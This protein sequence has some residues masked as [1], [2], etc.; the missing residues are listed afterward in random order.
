MVMVAAIA[1]GQ[2]GITL[3]EIADRLE[4]MRE[5]TPRGRSKWSPSSVKMLLDRAR[6]NGLLGPAA[7]SVK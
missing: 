2:E 3:A 1:G 6:M 4:Q 7:G 5:R